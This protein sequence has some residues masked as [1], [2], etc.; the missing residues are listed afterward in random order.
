MCNIY[1]TLFMLSLK[2]V[3]RMK[4]LVNTGFVKGCDFYVQIVQI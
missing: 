2:Y 3:G 1:P 4:P